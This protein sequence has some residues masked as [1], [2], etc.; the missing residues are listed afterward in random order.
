MQN[1]VIV[2]YKLLAITCQLKKSN[3]SLL[4]HFFFIQMCNLNQFLSMSSFGILF[5]LDFSLVVRLW[6]VSYKQRKPNKELCGHSFKLSFYR[7]RCIF[8]HDVPTINFHISLGTRLKREQ[9]NW[10]KSASC[11]IFLFWLEDQPTSK[12][13]WLTCCSW[14]C[15][16]NW[17]L[18]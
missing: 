3:F 12:D 9:N 10:T 18:T 11:F 7:W 16:G 17:Y 4:W 6:N 1:S 13:V 8:R 15:C 2:G 5:R 14:Q